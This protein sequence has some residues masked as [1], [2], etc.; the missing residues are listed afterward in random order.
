MDLDKYRSACGRLSLTVFW[1]TALSQLLNH[2]LS[3]SEL[4]LANTLEGG[5]FAGLVVFFLLLLRRV[6]LIF[7]LTGVFS[8]FAVV[9]GLMRKQVSKRTA[10]PY[11]I[12]L[13]SM[14]WAMISRFHSYD[15]K[16]SLFGYPGREEG[17][18]ALLMYAGIFYLGTMLRKKEDLERFARGLMV[19]GIVQCAVGILQALPILDYA[20]PNKGLNP[21]RNIEPLLYWNIRIP[22]GMASSPITFAM[23]LALLGA[24]AVPAALFAA[25]KKTRRLAVICAALSVVTALKTQ[26]IAGMTAGFGILLLTVILLH[27]LPVRTRFRP[28]R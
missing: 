8:L 19:F 22:T 1:A 10:V 27:S 3:A 13:A 20:D 6:S 4:S 11:L 26:T 2:M 18:F 24:A 17:W 23:L 21:Y 16:V 28:S 25:E 12:L 9:A 15:M 7:S 5:G 14:V